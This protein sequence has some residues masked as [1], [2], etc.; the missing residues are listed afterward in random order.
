MRCKIPTLSLAG[1]SALL[2]VAACAG[3][4][5]TEARG[6]AAPHAHT[7]DF[8][9]AAPEVRAKLLELRRWSAPFHNLAKA[10]EA[11]YG[12][13]FGCVD[14]SMTGVPRELARGMGHHVGGGTDGL[15]YVL[16]GVIDIDQPEFLVYAPARAGGGLETARL[17]GFDYFLPDPTPENSLQPDPILGTEFV[18]N[19]GFDGWMAHI[20][21]WGHNPEGM[22]ENWNASVP[23]CT[24]E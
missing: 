14:E 4:T 22:F 12:V 10:A 23:L 7:P 2:A 24:A 13:N 11:G 1:A 17:V 5:P 9:N 6:T 18:Y 15:A 3:E 16:D 19:P 8:I 21:L 20:Y